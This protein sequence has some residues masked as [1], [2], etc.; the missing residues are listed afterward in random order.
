MLHPTLARALATAHVEDRH[1]A[2]VR[3]QTIRRARRVAREPRRAAT[4]IAIVR[5]AWTRLRG[6]RA[7]QVDGITPTEI[8]T[9]PW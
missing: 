6:R 9:R 5:S 2:A 4:P 3:T 1:R 8:S 7:P